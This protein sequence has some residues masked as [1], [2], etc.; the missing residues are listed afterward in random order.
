MSDTGSIS[1][2]VANGT[3]S[4]VLIGPKIQTPKDTSFVLTIVSVTLYAGASASGYW[5]V[6]LRQ[7]T[8][9]AGAA[10][11]RYYTQ[12]YAA[13]V[14]NES[15]CFIWTQTANFTD[16]VQNCFTVNNNGT[17][18]ITVYGASMLVVTF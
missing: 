2:S 14:D 10:N 1:L 7:G 6:F 13:G 3:E 18:S 8:T 11:P 9:T 12:D 17:S 16:Y 5:R 15:G 4:V